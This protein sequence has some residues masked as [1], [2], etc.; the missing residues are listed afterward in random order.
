MAWFVHGWSAHRTR[1][2]GFLYAGR[3]SHGNNV[4][5]PGFTD[6][7]DPASTLT[8]VGYFGRNCFLSEKQPWLASANRARAQPTSARH[9]HGA[10]AS[11]HGGRRERRCLMDGC[12]KWAPSDGLL[13]SSPELVWLSLARSS[14][15]PDPKWCL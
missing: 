8:K 7:R 9:K 6:S 11:T 12:T 13:A 1:Q 3:L 2:S 14:E 15:Q 5:K 4:V 10:E